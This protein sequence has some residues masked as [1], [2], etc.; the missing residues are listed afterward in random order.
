MEP[1]IAQYRNRGMYQ[2]PSISKSSDEFAF[3]NMNIRI[4]AVDDNT[5]FS[6]TNEKETK[7]ITVVKKK[8]YIPNKISLVYV[9]GY[10]WKAVSE[11][12]VEEDIEIM[13]ETEDQGSPF[14]FTIEQG[15]SESTN[16]DCGHSSDPAP[17]SVTLEYSYCYEQVFYFN[18]EDIP[19]TDV[20]IPYQIAG[21]YIGKCIV[22]KYLVIF[23]KEDGNDRIYRCTIDNGNLVANLLTCGEYNFS[24][25]IEAVGSYER[26]DI[27]KVYWVDG[28]NPNRV[29]NIMAETQP[30]NFDFLPEVSNFPSVQ[31]GKQYGG[32]G[33][34][35]AGVIQ[36]FVSY[37]NKL[38]QETKIV[39]AT[40]LQYISFKD[41][42]GKADEIINMSFTLELT[43]LDTRF[44][45]VRVYSAKRSSIDGPIQAQIVGDYKIDSTS[46]KV[47]DNNIAQSVIDSS[48]LYYIGGDTFIA[49]TIE[50]KDGVL[51]FGDIQVDRNKKDFENT[52]TNYFLQI[53]DIKY[54][55][56]E[57]V[58][59]TYKNNEWYKVA[60]QLQYN[61][62]EW[63]EPIFVKNVLIEDMP[64]IYGWQE[65][66]VSTIY[67]NTKPSSVSE[68]NE[69][70][71]ENNIVNYRLLIAETSESTRNI[72]AQGVI[73]PTVF[74][75]YERYKNGPFSISSWI[76]R[77][78]GG[79][80]FNRHMESV[81][82]DICNA[83][84][85]GY[86]KYAD[87]RA[88]IQFSLQRPDDNGIRTP[89]SISESLI[90]ND[91][92]EKKNYF[93]VDESIL[94]FNS[95]EITYND[96]I[97]NGS[98]LKFR[99]VGVINVDKFYSDNKINVDNVE[100]NKYSYIGNRIV[101]INNTTQLISDYLYHIDN[102]GKVYS[103]QIYPWQKSGS[104]IYVIN[105]SDETLENKYILNS[106]I[107]SNYISSDKNYYFKN[108]NYF[109]YTNNI[110]YSIF[111][112]NELIRLSNGKSY[113]GKYDT[114][115]AYETNNRV[116]Y[117]DS[118]YLDKQ[119]RGYTN[120][121]VRIKYNTGKHAIIDT[122]KMVLPAIVAND[123]YLYTPIDGQNSQFLSSEERWLL[124]S[125]YG[126][127]IPSAYVYDWYDPN[128]AKYTESSYISNV[129][130]DD[131][132][133]TLDQGGNRQEAQLRNINT[134][135]YLFIGELYRG[136]D[137]DELYGDSI[138]NIK[139]IPI[140][141]IFS[142]DS[143]I[144]KTN[145][146]TY[147]KNWECL[148]TY[149]TTEEDE[150]SVVDIVSF[151]VETHINLDGRCDIN[152]GYTN[153]LNAR[154]TNFGLMN[155]VYSQQN[156]I[157]QYNI[158]D[159]VF[160]HRT[161][162][163]QFTWSR[164]KSDVQNID[165][166]TSVTLSS[167][168]N[169][170][171]SYGP[172]NA[173]EKLNDTLIGFQDRAIFVINFNNRTQISTE[174]GL[175]VELANS[176]KVDGITYITK[177]YGCK[178]KYSIVNAKSGIYF[179]DDENRAF[180]CVGKDGIK[181]ISSSSG[182]SVWFKN[183]GKYSTLWNGGSLVD[184][185]FVVQYDSN[186]NDIY[187]M[188]ADHSE[189]CIVYNEALQSFTSFF[190]NY[191]YPLMYCFGGKT[192][193][194]NS[195][196]NTV[197]ELFG[198]TSYV[199]DYSIQYRVNP[200]PFTE[201]TFTNIDYLADVFEPNTKVDNENVLSDDLPFSQVDA[202]NE[203]Q[204]GS[205]PILQ[206][207]WDNYDSSVKFRMRRVNIPRC[208]TYKLDR[209]KNPW[210]HLKLSGNTTKKMEFHSIIVKYFK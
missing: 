32:N 84:T 140:S 90:S 80:A 3:R 42:G 88:E 47:T 9:S 165:P 92:D 44:D 162:P 25:P 137:V 10:D 139:W 54:V 179:I 108:T 97:N 100:A 58:D 155:D 167:I 117:Y 157:F 19:E 194:F 168:K 49:S 118:T 138:A 184:T 103:L 180:L 154:P 91:I 43:N 142:V 78:R 115:I 59:R 141:N 152:K 62:G 82:V 87:G 175:P 116:N 107:F 70:F 143:S 17:S 40:D 48:L 203:Y 39:A 12:P 81:N 79:R 50:D 61:T 151:M 136:L 23:T 73:N 55:P 209:M 99:I 105:D 164:S 183:A 45:Y 60:V 205:E 13:W 171:G 200:E 119:Y 156:N 129:I 130:T 83:P 174:Q 69:I 21:E 18:G 206:N 51:F 14:Y 29:I 189:G 123:I 131:S 11:L 34:F 147:Y 121:P 191:K 145:G 178:N 150:N 207:S 101:D 96:Y 66:Y 192:Y 37:Y 57:S 86:K 71:E 144:D 64:P 31:V 112:D 106:K 113:Y 176:G 190:S 109:K 65:T 74:N 172:I 2:D 102:E 134:S 94:S 146:D 26:D 196:N 158:L 30:D 182:M 20:T 126:S 166:W 68:L 135:S 188:S 132:V 185:S 52:I 173:I 198:G 27:I 114:V 8:T 6:V 204:K 193:G 53:I 98:N 16:E 46:I 77:P 67:I 127:L 120:N 122:N 4:T 153:Q 124:N 133:Y 201:K 75:I 28:V 197:E 187:I 76:S 35:P 163:Q 38:G 95:P 93:Y 110:Q 22:D 15:C 148:R 56:I 210:I 128:G 89:I 177:N 5:Q 72:V 181:D 111:D 125:I 33:K 149:P 104:L 170:D 160:D 63:S 7:D 199:D 195:S 161:F 24:D 202:W 186:T 85:D 159:D 169:V 1:G 36:Y 41:R 208:G